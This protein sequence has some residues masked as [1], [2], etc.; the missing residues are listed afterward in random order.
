MSTVA[1]ANLVG[2]TGIARRLVLDGALDEAIA[3]EA[4]DKATFERKPIAGYLREQKLVTAT[5]MAAANSIEFGMPVFD[6][7][8]MDGSQSAIKLVK[9]DLLQKHSVLPLYQRGRSEEHTSELQS[10]M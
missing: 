3:R 8:A 9:E 7:T 2:I 10:L 1:T 4:L 5:E 6:P